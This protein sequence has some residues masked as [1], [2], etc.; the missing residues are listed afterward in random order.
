MTISV[1]CMA[2]VS[3]LSLMLLIAL[4]LRRGYCKQLTR[5]CDDDDDDIPPPPPLSK[6]PLPDQTWASFASNGSAMPSVSEEEE[7]LP[8][9]SRA[10]RAAQHV[11]EDAWNTPQ[12][13]WG[14][15]LDI[16][17]GSLNPNW[18]VANSKP[19]PPPEP[20]VRS[21]AA[22]APGGKESIDQKLRRQSNERVLAAL[23]AKHAREQ[24]AR[25]LK[26]GGR[27]SA[28]DYAEWNP[29]AAGSGQPAAG[30]GQPA[31]GLR[32]PAAQTVAGAGSQEEDNWTIAEEDEHDAAPA[33]E[34]DAAAAAAVRGRRASEGGSSSS[35]C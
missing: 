32:Q 14:S 34:D 29:E 26:S 6:A 23:H 13:N 31:A 1:V 20:A 16:E 12:P 2:A 28:A 24:R 9:M 21:A 25:F 3:G 27:P 17:I 19:R 7:S 22:D 30:S 35:L 33:A 15:E 10:S 5:C 8:E 4:I 11:L 18:A